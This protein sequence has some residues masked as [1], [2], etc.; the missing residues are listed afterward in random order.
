[1]YRVK[2]GKSGNTT[3]LFLISPVDV[4]THVE[5]S[6]EGL[7]TLRARRLHLVTLRRRRHRGRPHHL[8][9]G[10]HGLLFEHLVLLLMRRQRVGV[11]EPE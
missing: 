4:N 10:D 8:H 1:M 9:V 6:P 7:V 5:Q 2:H 11:G 3:I